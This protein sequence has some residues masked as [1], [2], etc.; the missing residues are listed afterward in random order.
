MKVFDNLGEAARY[1][2][3]VLTIGTFDG[4]HI[5]HRKIIE[6][7]LSRGKTLVVTFDKLPRRVMGE[8]VKMLTTW[9]EKLKLLNGLGVHGVLRLEFDEQLRNMEPAEFIN[10]YIAPIAPKR[11]VIGENHRFG[12]NRKGDASLLKAMG[13]HVE[14]VPLVR[15]DDNVVSSTYIRRLLMECEVSEANRLLG[16]P[17]IISGKKIKGAGIGRMLG[18]PTVNLS[19]PEDKLLPGEG[20]YGVRVNYTHPALLH[21]GGSPTL[22]LPFRVELHVLMFDNRK[23]VTHWEVEILTYLRPNYTFKDID[24]IIKCIEE[25]KDRFLKREGLWKNVRPVWR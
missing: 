20:V 9:E 13:W 23:D 8:D 22:G 3:E 17:Y 11:I 1:T 16:Y 24:A 14:V 5:G 6:H 15:I 25:D 18:Y 12:K 19:I 4:I 10:R 21:I 7:C 2:W